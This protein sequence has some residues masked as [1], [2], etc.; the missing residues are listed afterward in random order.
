MARKKD[1]GTRTA[2]WAERNTSIFPEI[3]STAE[4]FRAAAEVASKA[5]PTR[6]D[7]PK[8]EM[9]PEYAYFM[10]KSFRVVDRLPNGM[11]VLCI[12]NKGVNRMVTREV[13]ESE[14]STARSDDGMR[15]VGM[16]PGA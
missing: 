4:L 8:T 6:A 5:T 1:F 3:K 12:R 7:P 10:D 15:N 9:P 16:H 13:H 14:I 11:V 2:I